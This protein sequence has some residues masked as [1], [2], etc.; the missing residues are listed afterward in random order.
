MSSPVG[1]VF[2]SNKER[3]RQPVIFIYS[4]YLKCIEGKTLIGIKSIFFDGQLFQL[5]FT[6]ATLKG[7][8]PGGHPPE[9][10]RVPL[11]LALPQSGLASSGGQLSSVLCRWLQ[12]RLVFCSSGDCRAVGLLD[13]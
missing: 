13:H 1:A 8:N 2:P 7:C 12:P 5:F 11:H 10:C 6:F 3:E 4:W 9:V